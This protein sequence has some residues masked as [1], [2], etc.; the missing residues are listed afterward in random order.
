M[1]SNSKN[2]LKNN[3][4]FKNILINMDTSIS[5]F[6]NELNTYNKNIKN[7][8][9][10]LKKILEKR[11]S[12][13]N[14]YITLMNDMKLNEIKV[15]SGRLKFGTSLKFGTTS[16]LNVFNTKIHQFNNY[17]NNIMNDLGIENINSNNINNV[18]TILKLFIL[19]NEIPN[20][21]RKTNGI[22]EKNF[23]INLYKLLFE[24]IKPVFEYRISNYENIIKNKSLYSST[25]LN[26]LNKMDAF[27]NNKIMTLKNNL[28]KNIEINNKYGNLIFVIYKK[29]NNSKINDET[30]NKIIKLYK[31]YERKKTSMNMENKIDY[32][33]L[34]KKFLYLNNPISN[35]NFNNY[36]NKNKNNNNLSTVVP[37]YENISNIGS[38]E[39]NVF[40]YNNN[41]NNL[42]NNN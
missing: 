25:F 15:F 32:I 39:T 42:N 16:I 11:I 37:N 36:T 27:E 12:D 2:Y 13:Y 21:N 24:K 19:N 23:E 35:N 3:N 22:T 40:E 7:E 18:R 8:L 30:K 33:I 26:Q 9:N 20:I 28:L 1:N 10:S 17:L 41:S 5:D 31:T 34:F 6:E 38:V 29:N 14:N 4:D